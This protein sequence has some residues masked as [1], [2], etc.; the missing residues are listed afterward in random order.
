MTGRDVMKILQKVGICKEKDYPYGLIETAEQ[1]DTALKE[2]AQIHCIK[3]YARVYDLKSLKLSLYKNGPCLIAF[4]VYN[5][6][7]EMWK[8]KDDEKMSGGHAMTVVGYDK[9]GFII[10]NSWGWFWNFGGYCKYKYV[11]WGAHWEIWTTIDKNTKPEP[12]VPVEPVEPVEPVVPVNPVDP[13][14]PDEKTGCLRAL[15]NKLG[16]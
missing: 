11:D 4:P 8:Q 3:K 14:E 13:I 1:I 9:E 7:S 2:D 15:L 6:G 5:T 12:L 10:R 16:Y